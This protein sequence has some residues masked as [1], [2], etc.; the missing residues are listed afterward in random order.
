MSIVAEDI[1]TIIGE[2]LPWN[3]LS[4]TTVL[5]TG[6]SG[7]VGGYLVR[8]L[9]ALHAADA[10]EEPVRV[11]AMVRD[12]EKAGR[13]LADVIADPNLSLLQWDLNTIAVPPVSG[14]NVVLHAA[15]AATPHQLRSD[16]VGTLLPNSVGTIAL[17]EALRQTPDPRAFLFVSSGAAAGRVDEFPV[18]TEDCYG[19]LDPTAADA[20]YAEGKRLGEAAA[21]AWHR[22]YGIPTHI[23]RLGHTYGPGIQA[24]DGRVFAD[25]AYNVARGENIVMMSSG[26]VR[27][28][29]C[30]ATDA[31][32]GIFTV[33]LKGEP[34]SP[35]TV[36]NPEGDLAVLELAQLLVG[37]FPEKELRVERRAEAAD[38][39]RNP[40]VGVTVDVGKLRALGWTP[41]VSPEAGFRRMIQAISAS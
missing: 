18:F 16:P 39:Q 2:P 11:I 36:A 12:T 7:F 26:E 14:I 38:V 8:T 5:V 29:F 13:R 3:R 22:Q 37:M 27:R 30:Y 34:A 17:L 6:A 21:A 19:P 32:A 33:L 24:N 31:I 23:A 1:A 25:F 20:A 10:V 15:S 35:Y 4:G 41:R 9:L 40:V 28:Q